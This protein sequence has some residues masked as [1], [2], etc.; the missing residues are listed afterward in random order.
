MTSPLSPMEQI[1]IQ[2]K[3]YDTLRTEVIQRTNSIYQLYGVAA[4]ASVAISLLTAAY[5]PTFGGLLF[6]FFT[7]VAF[8]T[9]RNVQF[10]IEQFA[11]RLR[12]LENAINERAG[13][14]LLEWETKYGGVLPASL[15]SRKEHVFGP[16]PRAYQRCQRLLRLR[17]PN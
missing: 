12:E 11:I 14:T 3:E 17:R 5:S 1:G 10:D 16:F 2:L 15:Q 7:I 9:F 13:V 6:I 4:S 8:I